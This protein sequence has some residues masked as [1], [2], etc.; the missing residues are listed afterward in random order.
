MH[1]QGWIEHVVIGAPFG[2]LALNAQGGVR[3]LQLEHAESL[4]ELAEMALAQGWDAATAQDIRS[5]KKLIDLELQ[6]A[7]GDSHQPQASASLAIAGADAGLYAAIFTI[8]EAFSPGLDSSYERFL[9]QQG[10][11]QLLED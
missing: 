8:G 11:R 7:L 5:G 3:W 2:V 4:Q 10:E 9:T 6:L 1:R